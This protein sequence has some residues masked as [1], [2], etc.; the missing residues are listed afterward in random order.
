MTERS[1]LSIV[2]AA[3]EGTRMKSDR[4]KVLHEIAGLP[5]AAHV[6]RAAA[7][8]GSDRV[9]LVV[10]RDAETVEAVATPHAAKVTTYLQQE[11]L[12]TA[13]AVLAASEAIKDGADDIL[14]LFGDTPL[15]RPEDLATAR[16]ALAEGAC[17]AVMGFYTENPFGYGRLIEEDGQLIDIRE[18][19]DASFLEKQIQFCNGGLMAIAGEH[20]LELL[21]GIGNENAKGEYY[22][23]DIVALARAK[24]HKV[25]A[26]EIAF[27]S[28]LGVNNRVELAEAE[29]IW[30][31][32]TRHRM[33]V[34]GVTLMQPASV[35]FSWDT[36]IGQDT[37]VEPNVVFGP[38][39]SVGGGV[40]I[41]AF[42]H[43][44]GAKIADNAEVGPFARLRPGAELAQNSKVGNFC[45]VKKASI[46]EGAKVNHLT[47]IG[48]AEIGARSN[49]G[50]GT[51]TC[52]YDGY[53][54]HRTTIGEDVFVGTH[55]SLIAPIEVG[56]GAYVATGS[57]LTL[58]V[59]ADALAIAR[60]R[61]VNMDGRAKV[62]RQSLEAQKRQK[63]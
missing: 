61:Q 41:R 3:G 9:A 40:T 17:V 6:V 10:G 29:A 32:R 49:I 39:V 37:L 11:R 16:H 56:S 21:H 35:H 22:L 18:E 24:G 38:S 13:H 55:T 57:V 7:A 52:N 31:R 28:V 44:E 19:K 51:V 43:I 50:A 15:V 8:A 59:P 14:V 12:G 53:S 36:V 23:T 20:A 58:N 48:D 46:G 27:E 60:G 62:L 25:V 30:Q 1:C 42:S 54:K 34:D 45:E 33:M 2:L 26:R 4:S 47:Y 5:L 63:S